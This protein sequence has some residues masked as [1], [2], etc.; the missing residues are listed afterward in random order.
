[1]NNQLK[2]K[3]HNYCQYIITGK[4]IANL[5]IQTRYIEKAKNLIEKEYK[6][7]I[8]IEP[9]AESWSSLWIYKKEFMIEIIKAL[10]DDPKTIYDHWVLGKAFGYSDEELVSAEAIAPL[11]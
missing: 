3:I 1:M 8:F 2:E 9:L 7:K 6:L 5:P 10:P 4:S 11:S